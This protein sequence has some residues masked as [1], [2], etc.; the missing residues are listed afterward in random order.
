M[1][2]ILSVLT[3]P[4]QPLTSEEI[5]VATQVLMQQ[6][7]ELACPV[8]KRAELD[9]KESY[10][11]LNC[12]KSRHHVREKRAGHE[13]SAERPPKKKLQGIV[14]LTPVE[15]EQVLQ[16]RQHYPHGMS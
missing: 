8:Y 5:E 10:M 12:L 3:A 2:M 4:M 1:S 9:N 13:K 16:R 7:K 14:K 15:R 6:A 11:E